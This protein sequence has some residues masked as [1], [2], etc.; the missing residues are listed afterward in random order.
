MMLPEIAKR[1][2]ALARHLRNVPL[3]VLRDQN[4]VEWLS[5]QAAELDRLTDA[6]ARINGEG[7]IRA[8]ARRETAAL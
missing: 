3:R 4:M 8:R 6:L 5:E 1:Q 7:L 2:R